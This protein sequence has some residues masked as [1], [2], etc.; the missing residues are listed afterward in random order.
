MRVRTDFKSARPGY[1]QDLFLKQN[2][3]YIAYYTMFC[4]DENTYDSYFNALNPVTG[5][6]SSGA[7]PGQVQKINTENVFLFNSINGT[8]RG[9]VT[10]AHEGLHG[11]GL[12][13]THKNGTPIKDSDREYTFDKYETDN[14]MAYT[15]QAGKTKRSLWKW[16]WD[17]IKD[18]I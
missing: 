11:F 1:V 3:K 6:R 5:S 7:V 2:P 16:Q 18:N 14:F 15:K 17:I 10:I 12:P 13:H 4:F 9:N 8:I